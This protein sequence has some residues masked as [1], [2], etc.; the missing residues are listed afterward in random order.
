M[1]LADLQF[2]PLAQSGGVHTDLVTYVPLSDPSSWTVTVGPSRRIVVWR[3]DTVMSSRTMSFVP[4]RPMDTV[5][6]SRVK[7]RPSS[8]PPRTTRMG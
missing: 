3:R 7:K 2:V 4:C 8:S 5:S 1:V 6:E